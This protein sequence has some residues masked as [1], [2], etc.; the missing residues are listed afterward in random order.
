MSYDSVAIDFDGTI[1]QY[2]GFQGVGVF[3][4]PIEGVQEALQK[5]QDSGK[6][7]IIHTT[8]GELAQIRKYLE[9]HR[10]PYDHLNYNPRQLDNMSDKKPI[11]EV[12]VDDR[13][14]R[15]MGVWNDK[16]VEEILNFE[17]W[18]KKL[19]EQNGD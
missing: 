9:K 15:F 17:P 4:D 1:S 3:G 10:V 13:G 6:L 2:R 16:L 14:L 18:Y 7:I 5:I 12:Y 8:R 19:E 11:A